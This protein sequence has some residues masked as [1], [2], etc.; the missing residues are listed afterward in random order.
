MSDQTQTSVA[1]NL[2]NIQAKINAAAKGLPRKN[3]YH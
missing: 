1:E 2:G 3:R